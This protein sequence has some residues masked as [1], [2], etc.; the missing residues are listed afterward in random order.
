MEGGEDRRD[1]HRRRRR[2]PAHRVLVAVREHD[3]VAAACPVP[4]PVRER[5]PA[6]AAG[7]DMEEDDP[8]G[9]G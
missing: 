6:A 8:L 2:D 4:F 5:Q 3:D 9:P 1:R 7:H